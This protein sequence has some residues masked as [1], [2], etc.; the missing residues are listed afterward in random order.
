MIPI[1][2]VSIGEEEKSAVMNVLN[3]G[4]LTSGPKVL[5][6]E[7]LFAEYTG[8]KYAVAVNSGTAALQIALMAHGIGKGDEVITSPFTFI[9]T[10]NSIL[11]TGARPIFADIEKDT[12]N[13]DPESI[14]DKITDKTVAIL[15][16]HLYGHPAD[17]KSIKE[18][19]EDY[20][21][22]IIEDACQAIGSKID[23]KIVGSNK[24]V[25]DNEESRATCFS[26][27]PTKNMTTIEGG[28]ITI[29]GI[30]YG[31][32]LSDK[33]DN[34]Q[35]INANDNK[36]DEC[37]KYILEYYNKCKLIRSHGAG[38]NTRYIHE[39][40]GYNF[41][42]TDVSATIGI[43]QLKKLDSFNKKRQENARYMDSKLSN[44]NGVITPTVREGYEHVFHQYT[45]R[46]TKEYGMNRDSLIDILHR[47]NIG[48]G[49]YYPIVIYR[50][51]LYIKLGYNDHLK[52]AEIMSNEV[53][54][55]PIHPG[56]TND[57]IDYIADV[58][59]N[60]G[61]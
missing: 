38:A 48:N 35:M 12:F 28:M 6:F 41:R 13:I 3:S 7:K 11:F 33:S 49:I 58:I 34:M 9:A 53:V 43:E 29:T 59:K 4:M 26:F 30:N 5:E 14:I 25:G 56:I 16:V 51:P 24:L 50:Q 52:N 44:I 17:M 23:N 18:I 47:K 15:P 55:L 54:S 8:S 22:M 21:L 20:K 60:K 57:D 46:I 61:E 32:Q 40:L 2:K 45:I 27:Y 36:N 31:R 42:M 37:D 39:L 19:A 1:S 10:A